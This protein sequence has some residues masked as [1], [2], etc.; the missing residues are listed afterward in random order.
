Q[1]MLGLNSPAPLGVAVVMLRFD[2]NL[3]KA[4]N[5]TAGN[6]FADAKSAPTISVMKNE[7]GILLVSITPAAG[8][9]I[10]GQG[11]LL[12]VEFEGVASGDNQI[13]FDLSNMHLVT[14]DG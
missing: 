7:G 10:S 9:A 2:A 8:T 11:S 13:S 1:L 5:V 14:S 12:N 4:T 6:L 3:M